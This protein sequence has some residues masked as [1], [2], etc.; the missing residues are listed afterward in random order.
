MMM[1]QMNSTNPNQL[2]PNISSNLN[3]QNIEEQDNNTNL[4]QN[5]TN[6]PAIN[7][8]ST[9]NTISQVNPMLNMNLPI[10]KNFNNPNNINPGKII[11]K[12]LI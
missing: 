5:Q 2:N 7:N 10:N 11:E 12:E 6:F 9:Q 8:Q 3:K 1:S 4:H